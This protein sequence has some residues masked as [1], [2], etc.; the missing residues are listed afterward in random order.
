MA[1][2]AIVITVHVEGLDEVFTKNVLVCCED[3]SDLGERVRQA[4]STTGR[5]SWY[6]PNFPEEL[7]KAH[8]FDQRAELI[9]SVISQSHDEQSGFLQPVGQAGSKP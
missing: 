9:F 6:D 4:L 7:V 2:G 1:T 5:D 8:S 3:F